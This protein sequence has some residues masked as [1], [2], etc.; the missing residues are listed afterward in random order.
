ML[1]HFPKVNSLS[2]NH[3]STINLILYAY[4]NS[5]FRQAF[6]KL[7]CNKQTVYPSDSVTQ[8]VL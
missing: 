2:A 8:T 4:G 1:L 6:Q 7:C 5:K 3:N